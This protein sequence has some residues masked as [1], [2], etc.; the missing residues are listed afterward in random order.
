MGV[1]DCT[2][3]PLGGQLEKKVRP[4]HVNSGYSSF[5]SMG[6]HLLCGLPATSS[7]ALVPFLYPSCPSAT[8]LAPCPVCIPWSLPLDE[9]Q[10]TELNLV[11]CR[12]S[13]EWSVESQSC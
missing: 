7:P 4:V 13:V 8:S 12:G 11:A 9:F 10:R 1:S 3:Q 6:P 2:F 5:M